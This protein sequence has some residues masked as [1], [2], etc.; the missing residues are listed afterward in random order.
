MKTTSTGIDAIMPSETQPFELYALRYARHRGRLAE[1]NYLGG[2]DFHDAGSDLDYYIWVAR[3]GAETYVIDTGFG[4]AAARERGRE[5][6]VTIP[7]ALAQLQLDAA[8][9]EQ[10]IITHLH[11]DHAGS[12]ASFPAA[13]FHLQEAE[14]AYATGPCM[15]HGALRHP[16][17]VENVVDYV[18]TLYQGRVRFHQGSAQISPG[19]SVHRV[20]G[21]TAGLQVVRVWTKR[22]WVVLASDATHLY[23][24]LS[25]Q[26][27][28]PVVYHVGEMLEG[29]RIV[30]ELADSEAHIV[31]GHDPL[32]MRRYPAASAALAGKV[33][34]LDA[35]PVE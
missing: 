32:V 29:Y 34:R 17:D 8:R 26:H 12:L 11:Y 15:C 16:Y 2:A 28:F 24:N 18:R 9:I 3:R 23:G 33:A 4:E 6:L 14:A 25:R 27:P 20:G 13:T 19:L 31:P 10:V 21:H 7:Q 35:E 5:L 22:G 30:R 1:H